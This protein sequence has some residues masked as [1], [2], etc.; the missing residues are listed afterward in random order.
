MIYC[1]VKD[2]DYFIG[3]D[4]TGD[5]ARRDYRIF[6]KSNSLRGNIAYAMLQIAGFTGK[7][8]ILDPFC[9]D[10]VI[11][12][13]A[14]LFAKNMSPHFYLKEKLIIDKKIAEGLDK[15]IKN[16]KAHI[17]CSDLNFGNVQNAKKNA[18][19]A[20]VVQ[21]IDFS[22]QELRY[23]F[24]KIPEVDMIISV[25]IQPGR[26]VPEKKVRELYSD[27]FRVKAKTI[28]LAM[29]NGQ[30]LIK[31]LAAKDYKITEMAVWQGQ[32]KVDILKLEHV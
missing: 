19:I 15:K 6:L 5:L 21:D 25:P 32:Q 30:E 12:I 1:L 31:E 8:M 3:F 2:D 9:R 29:M 10:G 27:M 18:K 26:V 23:L 24:L 16:C 7:E 20:G 11:L 28:V 17:I 22:R 4:L 14:A 13:E